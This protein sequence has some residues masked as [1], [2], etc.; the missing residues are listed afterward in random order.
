MEVVRFR[1][2]IAARDDHEI[3]VAFF[4]GSPEKCIAILKGPEE[5]ARALLE[6]LG[7]ALKSEGS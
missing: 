4:D 2:A 1:Y 6:A 7:S 3:V 5:A